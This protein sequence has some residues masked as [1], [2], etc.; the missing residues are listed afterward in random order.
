[1]LTCPDPYQTG[2]INGWTICPDGSTRR[3]A[4]PTRPVTET[5]WP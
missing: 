1:V 5:T 2:A 4:R 3:A